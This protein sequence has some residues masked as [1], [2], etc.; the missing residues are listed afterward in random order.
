VRAALE[1]RE[2]GI[3]TLTMATAH[4][5][6]FADAIRA[7]TGHE[8]P[9]PPAL[10]G[11]ERLPRRSHTLPARLEPVQRYIADTLA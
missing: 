10:A 8:P 2:P 4:P 6:K 5:A 3:P 1:N 9:L 11:L 7:A